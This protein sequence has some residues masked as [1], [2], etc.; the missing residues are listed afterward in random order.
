MSLAYTEIA[1]NK[2]RSWLL[3]FLFIG[4]LM[5]LGF[6]MGEFAT[7]GAGVEGLIIS[8]VVA[9]IWVLITVYQGGRITLSASGAKP[10]EKRDNR[11]LY[12]LVENLSIAAGLPTPKIYVIQSAALNAFATGRDPN[13]SAV[14]VTTGLM[15]KLDKRELEGVIA[16][17][18][19][20]IGNF[21]TRLMMI[22]T[23]LAGTV[24]IMADVFLRWTFYRRGGGG[25]RDG[26]LQLA[27]MVVG[28][29]LII[30]SPI[31]ATLIKL[32]ISRKREYLADASG[33][34][35]TRYPEGLAS[36]LEKISSDHTPAHF[37]TKGT[38][39]LYISNPLKAGTWSKWFSTHPPAQNR[40][41]KLRE[42]NLG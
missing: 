22:V 9:S 26:R 38:A 35:L 27:L 23:A 19:S 32:A 30:F 6:F 14:A 36:A 39:H 15:E 13:H 10:I 7:A 37:A 34:L 31:F 24:M 8:A 1:R 5:A 42:M 2:R 3:L 12:N 41:A 21:D 29:L 18:L 16:H 33:A 4:L 20:H 28:V 25:R 11:E 40:I 17:E